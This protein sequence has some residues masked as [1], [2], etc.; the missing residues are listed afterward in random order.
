MIDIKKCFDLPESSK[1]DISNKILMGVQL[2]VINRDIN[3]SCKEQYPLCI[4]NSTVT[5]ARATY[6]NLYYIKK[7]L[8]DD[9]V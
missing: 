5:Q 2:S 7:T 9:K 8:I 4:E 6:D 1:T 3:K